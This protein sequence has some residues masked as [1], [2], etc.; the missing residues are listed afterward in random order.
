MSG[1]NILLDTNI[2]L[3]LLNGEETLIPLLEEKNLFL[4]FITQLELLGNRNIKPNDILKIKQFISECTIID[5]T[6]EIKEF[7][8]SIRQKYSIKL[9]DSIIMATSLWL[10]MP[11][12]TADHDFKKIDIADLIYFKI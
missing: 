6:T 7:T 10:N 4:S 5:I 11:L 8:I 9:P 3:Y 2:V 12:I 1:N